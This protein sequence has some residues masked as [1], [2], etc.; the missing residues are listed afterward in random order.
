MASWQSNL[1]HFLAALRLKADRSL[2]GVYDRFGRVVRVGWTARFWEEQPLERL[3]ER[4]G[5]RPQLAK[6]SQITYQSGDT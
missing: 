2:L 1:R 5:D 6:S 4:R 3:L